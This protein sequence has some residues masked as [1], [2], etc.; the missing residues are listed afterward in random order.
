MDLPQL[1]HSGLSSQVIAL[2]TQSRQSPT[3]HWAHV[4]TAG[5]FS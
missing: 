5:L 2:F 3:W 1:G 4:A